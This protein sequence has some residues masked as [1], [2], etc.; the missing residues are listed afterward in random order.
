MFVLRYHKYIMVGWID[1][2]CADSE[3]RLRKK[4]IT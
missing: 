4:S 2:K 3:F 1:G